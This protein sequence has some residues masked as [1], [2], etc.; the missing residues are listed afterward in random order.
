MCGIQREAGY[1]YI[2]QILRAYSRVGYRY[3][4][5][6]VK[7]L[8]PD[9]P[10]NCQDCVLSGGTHSRGSLFYQSEEIKTLNTS[11]SQ[12]GIEPTIDTH[13]DLTTVTHFYHSTTTANTIYQILYED[14]FEFYF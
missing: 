9:L 13:H 6:S 3:R 11:L 10:T 1:L 5:P 14:F 8:L 12:L 4:K 7:M 2:T